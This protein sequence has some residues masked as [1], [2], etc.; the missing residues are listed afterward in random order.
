MAGCVKKEEAHKRNRHKTEVEKRQRSRQE[1][2]REIFDKR[3]R[4]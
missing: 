4:L 1:I 2:K 3:Q